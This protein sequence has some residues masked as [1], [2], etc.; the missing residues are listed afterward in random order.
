MEPSAVPR[1]TAGQAR[2][3]SS[4]V[5]HSRVIFCV[6]GE[7]EDKVRG[8]QRHAEPDREVVQKLHLSMTIEI[9]KV[10]GTLALLPT[11]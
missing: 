5:G 6:A 8:R 9:T 1:S 2:S 7:R 11:A 4:R 3:K 10:P